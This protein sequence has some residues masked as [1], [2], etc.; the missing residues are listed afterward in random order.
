MK[1]L[2]ILNVKIDEIAKSEL[3]VHILCAIN[4]RKKFKLFTVNNEF[5]VEAQENLEFRKVL[6]SSTV[7]VADSAGVV[8][9]VKKIH[10]KNIE[11]IPGADLFLDLV[12]M[13]NDNK[14]RIFLLGGSSGVGEETK[15]YISKN[16]EDVKV[17]YIDGI[18]ISPTEQNDFVLNK[19]NN[20][21]P[22]M[23][24]VALGAPK[25]ELWIEQ[26]LSLLNSSLIVGIGGTLDF[27][28]GRI[29]RAPQLMR[30]M[31]LEWL[32]R[33]IQQPSRIGRIYKALVV[34]PMLVLG[35]G[36]QS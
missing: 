29:K 36:K 27:V 13:A 5:I 4:E 8:W 19:I 7:S 6:N 17:D 25:Q 24:F 9:A 12:K 15:K 18:S 16:F 21:S 26:N 35:R 33:L 30:N 20:F 14:Y 34:F 23:L 10:Q 11:R 2:S 28:S 31:G 1:E 32:F 22:H 3:L